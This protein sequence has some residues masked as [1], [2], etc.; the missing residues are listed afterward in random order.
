MRVDKKKIEK[1]LIKKGFILDNRK[2]HKYFYFEF[3]GKRGPNTYISHGSSKDIG[4]YLLSQM[5]KQLK[6]DTAKQA[7]DL[8][9]CPM[10]L[11]K[12]IEI[13]KENNIF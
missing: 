4:N 10:T 1:N 5:R 7:Y 3:E 13:L 12:Y 6:L 9:T 8:F 2:H 11:D